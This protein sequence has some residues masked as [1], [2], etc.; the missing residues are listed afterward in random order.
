VE[1]VTGK[2]YS[3]RI[4]YPRGGP[5]NLADPGEFEEKFQSLTEEVIGE[6]TA[7]AI[8]EKIGELEKRESIAEL[9]RWLQPQGKGR[10]EIAP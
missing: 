6:R 2:K 4:D 9:W 1:T 7:T 10:G 3:T 8:L 5:E